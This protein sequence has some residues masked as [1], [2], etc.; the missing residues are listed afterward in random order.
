MLDYIGSSR[1]TYVAD[2]DPV[3]YFPGWIW[4]TCD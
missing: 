2:G 4:L 3:R 1:E